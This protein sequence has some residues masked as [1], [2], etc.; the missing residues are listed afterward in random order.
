ML[1]GGVLLASPDSDLD[2]PGLRDGVDLLDVVTESVWTM[3]AVMDDPLAVA[4]SSAPVDWPA[5][6]TAIVR[7]L[8]IPAEYRSLGV[9]FVRTSPDARG[10]LT[11]HAI[12]RKDENPSAFVNV[13]T[14]VYHDSGGE[15]VS[16]GFLD[17]ALKHGEFG[18]WIDCVRHYAEKADVNLPDVTYRSG[19]RIREATYLYR[20]A[21]GA[22]RYAVFRYRQPNGK[23]SF[24]QHPPDGK[25]GW[26]FGTGCMD[27]VEPLPYRLPELLAADP[28]E[29]VWIVEGEKDAERAAAE[30]LVAT[31]SHGGIGNTDK[32]WPH[33]A[34]YL[35]DRC[36]MIVP[37]N[38]AGGRAHALKV[39]TYLH[40]IARTTRIISL[41]DLPQ[42]GDLSDFFDGGRNVVDLGRIAFD[43]PIFDPAATVVA[44]KKA[45][46]P[47]R[48][49]TVAD[50]RP[51][52]TSD[53]WLWEGYIPS[54][55]LTLLAAEAGTGKTRFCFDLHRR[56]V[57]GLPWP[58]GA[59]ITV[60]PDSKVLW[61][62][63][64]NQWQE[65]CDIPTAFDIPDELVVLNA[66]A[67]DPYS[68]TS[69]ETAEEIADLEAR[70]QRVKPVL[71]VVDTITNTGDYKTESAADAKRQYKPLQEIANRC[72]PAI[73][74]VTHLNAGGKV[75]GRRAVEK[76]RVV[77]QMEC[78]DPDDQ[79]NRRKLSVTKSKAIKP[80][81]LGVTMGDSGNEYDSHPPQAPEKTERFDGTQKG[82]TPEQTRKCMDWLAVRLHLGATRVSDVRRDS[83][84]LGYSAGTLYDAKGRLGILESIDDGKKWWTLPASNGAAGNRGHPEDDRVAS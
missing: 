22:V 16:L 45:D 65:M 4:D 81:A 39:A 70:I 62:A 60:P 54:R 80:P 75:L 47:D 42:K 41:P 50:L 74:C 59:V 67:S 46:D 5:V 1:G 26:R 69:L 37:D 2:L 8:D 24:T 10:R 6:K 58:D 11:C 64:D 23:K 61:V 44:E 82:K 35:R 55:A 57:H 36:C 19:G 34:P 51:R 83:D 84:G 32:T 30:G 71:V 66:V 31:T 68:G 56:I 63:A 28:N 79:P 21:S 27:G 17:F 29:P 72:G 43:V 18:R 25:G 20:D 7:A 48:D 3:T 15:G 38:D 73:L 33:V 53:P 76:V 14:G 40:G 13:V 77:I 9:S 49:A 78:P 52:Q 12:G